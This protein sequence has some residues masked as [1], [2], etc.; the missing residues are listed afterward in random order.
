VL[1]KVRVGGNVDDPAAQVAHV[2]LSKKAEGVR[3]L[4]TRKYSYLVYY[5][6]DKAAE[7]IVIVTVQH[8]AR[9]RENVDA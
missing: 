1:R 9:R 4:V 6:L 8:S 2:L 3:K 5:T 7:E